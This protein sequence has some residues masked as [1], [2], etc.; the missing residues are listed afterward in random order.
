MLHRLLATTAFSAIVLGSCF[1]SGNAHAKDPEHYFYPKSKWVVDRVESTNNNEL[2]SCT[3]SNQ[4]NNGYRVQIAGTANGF[5]N[6]NL[7][8][9]QNVFEAGKR[10]EVMYQVPGVNKELLP[11]RA[12]QQNLLVSDLRNQK[13]FVQAMRESGVLDVNIRGNEFR[14][15]MTGFDAKMQNFTQCV[16]A[17]LNVAENTT[18]APEETSAPAL[19]QADAPEIIEAAPEPPPSTSLTSADQPLGK[20]APRE[21]YTEQI[22]EE[23]KQ[24][25]SQYMPDD[26]SSVKPVAQ[27][28]IQAS[29][30]PEDNE[31]AKMIAPKKKP[32]IDTKTTKVNATV[33]FT[34]PIAESARNFD[35]IEPA[36]GASIKLNAL[37][38]DYSALKSEMT[39]LRQQVKSLRNQNRMLDEELRTVS[40]DSKAEHVSVASDNWNLERATMRFE[41]A[42]RQALRVG[43]QLKSE[44][45]RCDLEK[46]ELET[47]LFDPQLTNKTQLA[48][49]ASLE[50]DLEESKAEILRQK[51]RYDERVRLLEEQLS[52]Q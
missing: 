50:T 5:T 24:G 12:F 51:R 38:D 34:K 35:R 3:I 18:S 27:K 2:H 30:E 45:A 40:E 29:A 9:K 13:E 49:L 41:E 26:Q 6:I 19:A 32:F 1:V 22:E 39:Q 14:I 8:L 44:R 28:S 7:D 48:K 33:D 10:Y 31:P 25:N 47:L 11:T 52:A 15:Y 17:G 43:R 46:K 37:K 21:R 20:P 16:G 4:L 23:I 36:S 42:E